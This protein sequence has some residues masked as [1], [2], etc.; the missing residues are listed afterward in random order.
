MSLLARDETLKSAAGLIWAQANLLI[1]THILPV[2]LGHIV[3][4]I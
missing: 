2:I 1:Y 3:P 4:H